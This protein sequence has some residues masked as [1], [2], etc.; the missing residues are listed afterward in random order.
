M[1]IQV[2]FYRIV[3][4]YPDACLVDWTGTEGENVSACPKPTT[5]IASRTESNKLQ[6]QHQRQKLFRN[7]CQSVKLKGYN[8]NETAKC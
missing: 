2:F 3:H 1:A 6:I 4:F 8:N 7:Q 5:P